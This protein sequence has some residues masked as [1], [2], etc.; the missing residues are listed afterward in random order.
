MGA[1]ARIAA[2]ALVTF[3]GLAM[4]ISAQGQAGAS[5]VFACSLGKKFVSVTAVGSTLTYRF[6]T[7]AKVEM[8]IIGSAARGN[9]FYRTDRYASAQYQLRFA[10]G[11]YS[12]IVYSMGGNDRTGTK[13]V[14][15]LV[16]MKGARR[17]SD[18]SCVRQAEFSTAFD[19]NALPK[20]A[21]AYS[22]M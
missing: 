17:I 6:G 21:E 10:N 15:G 13:P 11:P 7:P 1:V 19:L 9:I 18:M 16:V 3:A 5:K 20:D 22:A 12:Y 8:A 14:S 2:I 4:P